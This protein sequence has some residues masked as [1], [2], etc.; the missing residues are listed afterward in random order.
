MSGVRGS[1]G[2]TAGVRDRRVWARLPPGAGTL[3]APAAAIRE[4]E[5]TLRINVPHAS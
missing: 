2:G 4:S 1:K 5:R 3:P